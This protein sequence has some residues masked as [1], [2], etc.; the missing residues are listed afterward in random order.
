MTGLPRSARLASWFNT[1]LQGQCS[2]DDARDAIVTPDAAHDVLGLDDAPVPIVLAL[3]RLRSR[4]AERATVAL[5]VPGDPVG[6][7]GPPEFNQS[8]IEAGEAVVV[9]GCGLGLVPDVVGAGVTWRAFAAAAVRT[10]PDLVEAEQRLREMLLE[11]SARLVDLDVARWR[12]DAVEGLH[13]LREAH[14]AP[15]PPGHPARAQRLAALGLRCQAI[16]QLGLGDDGGA[17][18]A[19]EAAERRDALSQLAR[20]ARHALVAACSVVGTE[21]PA[22]S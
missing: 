8:A 14:P 21:D 20:S 12:P 13:A 16:A 22:A 7:N 6:L 17:V 11:S 19:F 9:R 2:L 10:L 5:P 3:G 1:W 4:G 15:L 18:S